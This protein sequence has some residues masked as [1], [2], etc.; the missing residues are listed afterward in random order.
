VAVLTAALASAPAHATTVGG[1][2]QSTNGPFELVR[3]RIFV[4][5]YSV[6]DPGMASDGPP[7]S[8]T[9][10]TSSVLSFGAASH[11]WSQVALTEQGSGTPVLG[12]GGGALGVAWLD[13]SLQSGLLSSGHVVA[14]GHHTLT[15]FLGGLGVTVAPDAS[16]ATAWS[17]NNG[18]HLQSVSGGGAEATDVLVGPGDA[19]TDRVTV[20]AAPGGA[21]WVVWSTA[22]RLRARYVTADGA[23]SAVR[24]L[25]SADRT[26]QTHAPFLDPT[27]DY[28]WRTV[29]DAHGGLWVGLPH[30]LLHVTASRVSTA[31]SS[32]RPVV[33]AAGG[34]RVALAFLKGRRG[35]RVRLVSGGTKRTVRLTGRRFPID[36]TVDPVTG[37][38]YVL[39]YDAM[40]NV[41][42]S[43][44][45]RGAKHHSLL[46][47]FCHRRASG[48]VEAKGGLV[49]VACA[50]RYVQRDSVETG[51]DFQDGRNNLYV[52][53]RGGKVLRRQTVFEG[54]YSY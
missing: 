37:K 41:R 47:K 28:A 20:S 21:W 45:G 16:R 36:A 30:A 7:G 12:S 4:P 52:L 34:G 32:S 29:A 38:I 40:E 31:G 43:E 46:L 39:S 51:G 13:P 44:V 22:S 42:L 18:V 54:S 14:P 19:S 15:G 10:S 48:E 50:G 49:A 2:T 17:D 9:T 53:M 33:M 1:S 26:V 3:G 24:D 6:D 5:T 35:I 11:D 27:G 8:A 25:G 23:L